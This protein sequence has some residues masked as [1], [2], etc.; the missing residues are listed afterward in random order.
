MDIADV[1]QTLRGPMIPV[2]THLTADGR[3]V[4]VDAIAANVRYVVERGIGTG[5]GVLLAVGAGG[6]F[7]VLT[8]AERKEA[9]R[10]IVD[11]AA[12]QVPVLVGAQDTNPA[13]CI[14]MAQYA[15]EIGAYGIQTSPTYYYASSDGDC[16]RLFQAMHDA[17]SRIAIMIYNTYWEGYDLSLEQLQRLAELPRCRALKWSKPQGGRGYLEALARYSDRLAIVDNQGLQVMNHMLGGTGFITHLATIWPEH[18]LEVWRL[19]E[20]GEYPAAQQKL[21]AC[22]WPWQ[23]F[24]GKLW[25][26]TGSESPVVKAALE[27]VGRPGGPTRGPARALDAEEREE[28]RTLL[29]QIGVPGVQ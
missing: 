3:H 7:P 18:D 29:R 10:A 23:T 14:E 1:K 15:E 26:R 17:T 5:Q 11:A 22:N 16:Q 21:I 19:M 4:D 12:G 28:L 2:I 27:L 6:D 20:A 8:V 13:V 9:C 25:D 24:R